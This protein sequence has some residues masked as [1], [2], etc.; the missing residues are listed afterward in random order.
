M[1]NLDARSDLGMNHGTDGRTRS[2]ISGHFQVKAVVSVFEKGN[3]M[4][5]WPTFELSSPELLI[6]RL[7]NFMKL[8]GYSLVFSSGTFGSSVRFGDLVVLHWRMSFELVASRF[9]TTGRPV[10]RHHAR[11]S[12]AWRDHGSIDGCKGRHDDERDEVDDG[13]ALLLMKWVVDKIRRTRYTEGFTRK[14]IIPRASFAYMI[15]QRHE[16]DQRCPGLQQFR[17]AQV[18]QILHPAGTFTKIPYCSCVLV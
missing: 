17:P 1:D 9:C 15:I 6:E 10:V 16:Y 14:Y 11:H 13:S 18:D 3:V 5:Y 8:K 4:V 2:W 12:W 7:G